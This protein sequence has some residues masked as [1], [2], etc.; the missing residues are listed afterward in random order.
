MLN[1]SKLYFPVSMT[2]KILMATCLGGAV[3]FLWSFISWELLPWHRMHSFYNNDEIAE[4]LVQ[5]SPT[6]GVY[7]LPKRGEKG[8]DAEALT[9]G[10]LVYAVIRPGP[11]E[12]PW[13][14]T[15]HLIRSYLIQCLCALILALTVYRIRA[16]RFLSRA[17]VGMVMGL[18]AAVSSTLPFWN[19][20][21]LPGSRVIVALLDPF[22]CW[23]LAGLVI[24]AMIKPAGPR[25]IFT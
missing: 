15:K 18:F 24:A 19:W 10:P 17:A 8:L 25:R 5:N 12:Q 14:L 1:Y 20:F 11:L 6:H 9:R 2:K 13:S 16:F 7:M 23:T 3:A 4:S 22:I 21:E